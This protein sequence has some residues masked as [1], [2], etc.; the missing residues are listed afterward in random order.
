MGI[1]HLAK[2]SSNRFN[3]WRH[4]CLNL[5]LQ[6][7]TMKTISLFVISVLFTLVITA[8][9]VNPTKKAQTREFSDGGSNFITSGHLDLKRS[10]GYYEQSEEFLLQKMR[11]P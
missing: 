5:P 2:S 6:D 10:Y 7:F 4:F 9:N 3:P 1:I 11:N 8:C